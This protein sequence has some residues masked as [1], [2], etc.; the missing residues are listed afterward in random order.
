M[1][2][3]HQHLTGLVLLSCLAGCDD[4]QPPADMQDPEQLLAATSAT[5]TTDYVCDNGSRLQTRHEP[6]FD[7]LVLFMNNRAVRLEHV[8]AASGSQYTADGIVFRDKGDKVRLERDGQPATQCRQVD[9][10]NA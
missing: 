2:A 7:R 8:R 9:Q 4:R 3:R 6:R 10:D 1:A 5:E